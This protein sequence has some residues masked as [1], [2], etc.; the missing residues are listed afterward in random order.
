ME[1][2]SF[3]DLKKLLIN[4]LERKCTADEKLRL[5]NLLMMP[6]NELSIKEI[7]LHHLHEFDETTI[8][9]TVDFDLIYQRIINEIEEHEEIEDEKLKFEINKK[10]ID[11]AGFKV[12]YLLMQN[13]RIIQ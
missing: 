1:S 6:E 7:L 4:Y 8:E 9:S 5:Y 12:S 10:S 13:T 11:S 3:D 2:K